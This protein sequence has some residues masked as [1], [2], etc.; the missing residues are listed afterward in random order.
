MFVPIDVPRCR[1]RL[2][3]YDGRD[4]RVRSSWSS[5]QRS[6][7]GVNTKEELQRVLGRIAGVWLVDWIRYVADG[8]DV[9][10]VDCGNAREPT[11]RHDVNN[12]RI[13]RA[14]RQLR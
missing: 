9:R 11:R 7:S 14:R 4:G 12:T 10:N 1:T 5:K 13:N 2:A 3:W 8:M 6:G